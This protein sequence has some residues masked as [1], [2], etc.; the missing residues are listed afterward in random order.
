MSLL[1][2]L[3][4]VLLTVAL[5]VGGLML[6]S[7][8]IIKLE[9]I[10][11]MEIQESYGPMEAPLPVASRSIPIEGAAFVPG[12]G[13][14]SNPVEADDVS[15]ARGSQLYAINCAMCHGAAGEGNGLIGGALVNPPANLL[16]DVTQGKPD[17]TLFLTISN[18]VPGR[19][20]SLNENLTVRDRW[21][22]VNYIRWLKA[23]APAQP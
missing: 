23:N 16:S 13:S 7:Y 11:F 4:I 12:Q 3:T 22:V 10:S 19:M 9:W 20:P 5:G 15:I 18:G 21:D 1:S 17:G 2:R 6:I 14:P 8:D